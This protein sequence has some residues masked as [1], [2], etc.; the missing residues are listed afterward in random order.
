MRLQ[1]IIVPMLVLFGIILVD[2]CTEDP[3]EPKELRTGTISA[4]VIDE[5]L[6]Q[7]VEDVTITLTPGSLVSKTDEN[8]VA[9]F[10]V[11]PGNYFVDASVCC[12]G[13]G[14]IEYHLSVTV[15]EGKATRVT[16]QACLLCL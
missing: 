5:G 8:G 11:P 13:P 16:L 7:P 12:V 14:F 10:E 15:R 9:V 1:K 2:G 4:L 3:E 6:E